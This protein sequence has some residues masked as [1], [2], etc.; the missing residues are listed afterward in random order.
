MFNAVRGDFQ[1]IA[2]SVA[3]SGSLPDQILGEGYTSFGGRNYGQWKDDA[4]DD[5]FRAQS[6]EPDP[7][8]RKA[9]IHD[10]QRTP[11]LFSTAS[12]KMPLSPKVNSPPSATTDG[13]AAA[14][15]PSYALPT[16]LSSA[17]S[18]LDDVS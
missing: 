1:L 13:G 16:N 9:L 8:K 4:I 12:A 2:H 14:A 3:L 17:L 5:L 15:S 6:A 10:F 18:H 7:E 11:D